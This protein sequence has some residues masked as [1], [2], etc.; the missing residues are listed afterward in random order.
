M[1]EKKPENHRE[2]YAANAGVRIAATLEILANNGARPMRPR[3]L[4]IASA[5]NCDWGRV[6]RLGAI[7]AFEHGGALSTTLFGH[8]LGR[9][10]ILGPRASPEQR[11]GVRAGRDP[12]DFAVRSSPRPRKATGAACVA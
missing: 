8:H 6:H 5:A 2:P 11:R 10:L 9:E 7:L 3:C 12:L 4:V 1:L